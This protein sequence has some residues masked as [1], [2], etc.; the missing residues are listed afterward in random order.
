MIL[1]QVNQHQFDNLITSRIFENFDIYFL[2]NIR[3]Q[4]L[5]ESIKAQVIK[6]PILDESKFYNT[7]DTDKFLKQLKN[8]SETEKE[9]IKTII[10]KYVKQF[11]IRSEKDV[12]QT[13][14]KIQHEM[15]AFVIKVDRDYFANAKRNDDNQGVSRIAYYV[16]VRK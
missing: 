2:T 10:E 11:G 8:V 5:L 9:K 14:D 4:V 6:A 13:I 1:S 16:F 12:L 3:P 7:N 15:H